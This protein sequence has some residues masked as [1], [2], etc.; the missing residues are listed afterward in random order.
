MSDYKL[1]TIDLN[2]LN[3]THVIASYALLG[4]AGVA[5]I[6]T[7]PGTT[8]PTLLE[9]LRGLGVQPSDVR[10]VVVTHIHLDHAGAAG[11][12][13]RQGATVH[14]HAAGAPHLVDPSKLL[15]S[16]SRIYGDKMDY[17][18]GE[19]L[20]APPD[21]IHPVNDGDVIMV[22]GVELTAIQSPG[23][24]RHHHCFQIGDIALTGDATGVRLPGQDLLGVPA[25][26]PEFDLEAWQDTLKRLSAL[27]LKTIYPTHFGAVN[28]PNDHIQKLSV[29][30]AE[31]AEF[32]RDQ[33]AEGLSREAIIERY[34][35]WLD[36][37]SVKIEAE[38]EERYSKAN[39]KAMSVDGIMRYWAKRGSQ[40]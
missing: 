8:L 5:V 22:A 35:V 26:P 37:R 36:E 12:W 39:N 6:E 2:F 34:S 11:W 17:L 3:T 21:K 33:M 19:I 16:A 15:A 13:A 9:S 31:C 40:T 30:I 24:A 7:G 25:P 20:P 27:N 10:D 29:L 4:P 28:N 18:W 1:H 38:T 14:V 32:V 23:H